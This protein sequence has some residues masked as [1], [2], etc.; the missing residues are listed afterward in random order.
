MAGRKT[1]KT[2]VLL[3]MTLALSLCAVFADA[4]TNFAGNVGLTPY[5]R[6][7]WTG[8]HNFHAMVTRN[9][10][11]IYTVIKLSQPGTR[12][13]ISGGPADCK[14]KLYIDVPSRTRLTTVKNNS[15]CSQQEL[16][17]P[18]VVKQTGAKFM[19]L[20]SFTY[21]AKTTHHVGYTSGWHRAYYAMFLL[22]QHLSFANAAPR[23][24]KIHYVGDSL[25]WDLGLNV[26]QWADSNTFSVGDTLGN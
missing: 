10:I 2:E 24:P 23:T 16:L 21:A 11:I 22:I 8:N 7:E 13:F 5:Y 20:L 4:T 6:R 25:G 17:F 15:C 26:Q 3:V 18:P 12:F 14:M 9:Y 19:F 1:R